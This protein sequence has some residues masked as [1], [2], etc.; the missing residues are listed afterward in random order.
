MEEP[1]TEQDFDLMCIV[2]HIEPGKIEIRPTPIMATE[3]K[4]VQSAKR[5]LK[6]T[7]DELFLKL[8]ALLFKKLSDED[9]K[10]L[11]MILGSLRDNPDACFQIDEVKKN[12]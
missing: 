2:E 11:V 6:D 3:K 7:N 9:C 4:K 8:T 5:L 12:E 1:L 10:E